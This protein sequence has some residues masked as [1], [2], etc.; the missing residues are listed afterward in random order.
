MTTIPACYL[1]HISL[2]H[3][4]CQADS[5]TNS[6]KKK[7]H[8]AIQTQKLSLRPSI[9]SNTHC[10]LLNYTNSSLYSSHSLLL[11]NHHTLRCIPGLLSAN[12]SP[13]TQTCSTKNHSGSNCNQ[14]DM[15]SLPSTYSPHTTCTITMIQNLM[16]KTLLDMNKSQTPTQTH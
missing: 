5:N 9:P 4:H 1:R 7:I 16:T 12:L 2:H 8:T 14:E 10:L 11:A 6:Y 13:K 15:M 3:L